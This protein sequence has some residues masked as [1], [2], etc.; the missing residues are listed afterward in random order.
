MLNA[1]EVFAADQTTERDELVKGQ[2]NEILTRRV[3]VAFQT[4]EP[5]PTEERLIQVVLDYPDSICAEL[6]SLIGWA[7]NT[8]DIGFGALSGKRSQFLRA[9]AG[10]VKED[11]RSNMALL[12]L[13]SR[14]LEKASLTR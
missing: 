4:D 11:M 10:T 5:S 2:V 6:S 12:T 9:L 3:V 7:T 8:C 14:G 13:Q 1:L